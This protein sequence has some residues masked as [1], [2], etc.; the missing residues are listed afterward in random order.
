MLQKLEALGCL[1]KWVVELGQFDIHFRPCTAIKE[2]ALVDFLAEFTY[3]AEGAAEEAHENV[4]QQWWKLYVD[5]SSNDCEAGAGLMLISTKGYKITCALKLG[6]KA[7]NNKAEYEA[8]LTGL[9]LA[10]ELK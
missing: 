5:G 2:Q 1:L 9:R 8:F 6:F 4:E 3:M 10:K 7:S